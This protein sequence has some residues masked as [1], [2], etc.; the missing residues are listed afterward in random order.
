MT[1]KT[2]ISKRGQTSIP[3]QICKKYGIKSHKQIAWIDLGNIINVIPVNDDSVKKFRG[4]SKGLLKEL[5][6]ERKRDKK[7]ENAKK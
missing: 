6:S 5:L 2:T 1:I 7:R 4:S 3:S